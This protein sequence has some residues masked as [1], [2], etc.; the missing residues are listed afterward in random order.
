MNYNKVM[1]LSVITFVLMFFTCWCMD[2]LIDS[3]SLIAIG[4][5]VVEF[6]VLLICL[7]LS[8]IKLIKSNDRRKYVVYVS[9]CAVMIATIFIFPFETAKVHVEFEMYEAE[10]DKTVEAIKEQTLKPDKDGIISLSGKNKKISTGGEI[11]VFE[12]SK[13]NTIIGFW[14]YRGMAGDRS[15]FIVFTSTGQKSTVKHFE[16]VHSIREI[17]DNWYYVSFD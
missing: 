15:T 11:M 13:G 1:V 5:V 10:R 14:V 8:I 17:K 6:S 2:S 7:V 12:N 4:I 3:I 9:I 16:D